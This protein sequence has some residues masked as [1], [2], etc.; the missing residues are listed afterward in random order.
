MAD[1]FDVEIDQ[2]ILESLINRLKRSILNR[3]GYKMK[4]KEMLKKAPYLLSG[5]YHEFIDNIDELLDLFDEI[6]EDDDILISYLPKEI[7]ESKDSF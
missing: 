2:K 3:F 7:K 4:K 6:F 1:K 5:F